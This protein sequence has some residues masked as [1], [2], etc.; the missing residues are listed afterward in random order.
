[1]ANVL[2]MVTVGLMAVV[3]V[4]GGSALGQG[5]PG[6]GAGPDEASSVKGPPKRSWQYKRYHQW[7]LRY[8]INEK[9]GQAVDEIT[10]FL[11]EDPDD[12]E[13][14]F[15]LTLAH[16]QA[17]RVDEALKAMAMAIER[18]VPAGR[19]VAGPRHLLGGI[20]DHEMYQKLLEAYA[21]RLV[22]GP[23]LGDVTEN[24]VKIWVR[25]ARPAGVWA[26]VV[27]VD[28]E[29]DYR[30]TA[31]AWT[32]A[33]SDYTGVIAVS[34]LKPGANYKYRVAVAVNESR[35]TA[36]PWFEFKTPPMGGGGGG[37]FTIA[38]GGGSG[39]VPSH[40]RAW[41]TVKSFDPLATLLLGDNIYTDAPKEFDIQRYSYYRRQSRPEF[42]ALVA[43]VP[44]Y[45]IW[46]D[47]D[48][49]DNDSWGGPLIESPPWKR[50][51]W[52][53]FRENWVNPSYGGGEKQPGV[54]Y[55]FVL[56]DV[57]F[58]M[59]DGRYYRTNPKVEEPSMLGPVQLEWLKETLGKSESVFKVICS[60]VP[61]VIEAKGSSRDTWNGFVDEREEI[62]GLIEDEKIEG[63][64]L[65]SADR[66]RS[67][68]WRLRRENGYDFFEFN[69]SR[70]TNQHVHGTMK[71]AIFSYNAKQSFGV[72]TFDTTHEP[73]TVNYKVV[74][75]DGVVVNELTV[76]RD[77]LV[78]DPPKPSNE[79][80][81]TPE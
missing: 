40:E 61:W 38:F 58:I 25:T 66:H 71:D 50:K 41:E 80:T 24:G 23:M 22:H 70:L 34:G 59:L 54:W 56:G 49:S 14:Y 12:G 76:N 28:D 3:F 19:F 9:E 60:P 36:G 8:V 52:N 6:E 10:E 7:F 16:A 72:V 51:V 78:F 43:S 21:D 35:S 11:N 17:G 13:S 26:T 1:M 77:Q 63:V 57:H 30:V 15:V 68:A 31:T 55:D 29:N 5:A 73:A 18:G 42:R 65:M 32:T 74:N 62:F 53:V 64:V 44:T 47:H 39:Y 27:N 33:A 67:D 79:R 37:R 20:A 46:D 69:S 48:F 45:S 2:R 81:P 75:I 4:M